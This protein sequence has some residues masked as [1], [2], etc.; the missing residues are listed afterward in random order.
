MREIELQDMR[1]NSVRIEI[2]SP[3]MQAV[4]PQTLKIDDD[5]KSIKLKEQIKIFAICFFSYALLHVYREFWSMSKNALEIEDNNMDSELLSQ[6]DT[7][8][9]FTYSLCTFIGGVAGDVINVRIL[10]AA[11]F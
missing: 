3:S 6:F 1:S 5:F 9:L 2:D 4:H 8:Y 11:S 7:V 10:I